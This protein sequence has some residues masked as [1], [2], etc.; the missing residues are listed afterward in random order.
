MAQ[1]MI[2]ARASGAMATPALMMDGTTPG[3][4]SA[5]TARMAEQAQAGAIAVR[6]A[7]G[8][9]AIAA[10]TTSGAKARLSCRLLLPWDP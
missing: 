1:P 9:A 6:C 4:S 3:R 10:V 7:A 2:W 5:G 8:K